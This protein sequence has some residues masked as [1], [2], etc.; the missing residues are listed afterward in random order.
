MWYM[1]VVW[2][3]DC[4]APGAKGQLLPACHGLSFLLCSVFQ[5]TYPRDPQV[6]ASCLPTKVMGLQ[7][8]TLTSELVYRFL[9]P[10]S[11]Q[12]V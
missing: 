11:G 2:V 8:C 10:D 1:N 12:Q 6:A 7:I 9:E 5:A 3:H 4:M